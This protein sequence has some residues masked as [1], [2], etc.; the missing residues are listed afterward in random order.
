MPYS[1]SGPHLALLLL[2]WR[3]GLNRSSPGDQC[4]PLPWLTVATSKTPDWRLTLRRPPRIGCRPCIYNF[5]TPMYSGGQPRDVLPLI[6]TDASCNHCL[7][8]WKIRPC[9][10]S[11][12]NIQHFRKIEK[13]QNGKKMTLTK[14]K[15]KRQDKIKNMY[16]RWFLKILYI[17]WFYVFQ[18]SHRKNLNNYKK[19]GNPNESRIFTY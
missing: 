3:D 10:R 17:F 16:I 14:K 2:L 13:N 5:T 19:I 6:Y 12:C 8:S 7:H 4:W 11:V 9:Q 1:Y 18:N 15:R